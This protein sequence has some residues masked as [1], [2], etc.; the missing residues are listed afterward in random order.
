[1]ARDHGQAEEAPPLRRI[2]ASGSTMSTTPT[3]SAWTNAAISTMY[4]SS[5]RPTPPRARSASSSGKYRHLKK[6]KWK[7]RSSVDGE[8]RNL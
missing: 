3:T 2:H 6:L 8:T 4:P 5:S 7:G 1:M